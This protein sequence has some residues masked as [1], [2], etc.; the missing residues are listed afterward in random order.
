MKERYEMLTFVVK[1][2]GVIFLES[3]L[4]VKQNV[5]ILFIECYQKMQLLIV[6]NSVE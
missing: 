6:W 5:K 2:N 1:K 4:Q 3:M